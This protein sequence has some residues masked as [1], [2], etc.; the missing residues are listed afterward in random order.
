MTKLNIN[1]LHLNLQNA[2]GHEHRVSAIARRAASVFAEQVS[3]RVSAGSISPGSI[4]LQSLSAMPLQVEL[5]SM[6]NEQAAN[7][8][9]GAWLQAVWL[10]LKL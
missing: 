9:A 6:S 5:G 10:K 8:I 1:T 2:A 4:R 7:A 3:R